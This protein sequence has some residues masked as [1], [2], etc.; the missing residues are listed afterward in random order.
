MMRKKITLSLL[1][2]FPITTNAF[3][4]YVYIA[5]NSLSEVDVI[6]TA[7]N[8]V[9][10]RIPLPMMS[11]VAAQPTCIAI[12]P[13]GQTVSV[14]DSY[15]NGKSRTLAVSVIDA[16]QQI[17]VLLSTTPI[18]NFETG[19]CIAYTTDSSSIYITDGIAR[20]YYLTSIATNPTMT[21]TIVSIPEPNCIAIANTLNG[22]TGYV[23]TVDHGIYTIAIPANINATPIANTGNANTFINAITAAPDG[24]T[25]YAVG[26]DQVYGVGYLFAINTTSNTVSTTINLGLTNPSGIVVSPDGSE[27]YIT[28]NEYGDVIVI[29][30]DNLSSSSS[31]MSAGAIAL[32]VTPDSKDLY[33]IDTNANVSPYFVPAGT[34]AGASIPLGGSAMTYSIVISPLSLLPPS[35]TG[36]KTKNVFLLQTDYINNITWTAPTSGSPAAYAI[37][38]DSMLTQLVAIVPASEPLQYYDHD[39]NP[40]VTYTYYI[41]SV[42]ASGNQSAPATVTV[43]QH[44]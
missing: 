19:T 42:D 5:N 27:L 28:D 23:G 2:L 40:S 29:P 44:C 9:L 37:Y 22:E 16:T 21:G 11:G 34:S 33:V 25:V 12:A 35:V 1:M 26:Q 7:N 15:L 30:T 36:C 39:R 32:A 10:T 43:T 38:R 31:F 24:R 41:V 4:P 18:Q 17:P 8:S 20:I 14:A 3:P 13:N 6:N